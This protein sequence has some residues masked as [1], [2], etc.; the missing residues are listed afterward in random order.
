MKHLLSSLL[1]LA[2]MS[3]ASLAHAQQ[4]KV[5]KVKGQQ[6]I[7]QFPNGVP[8]VV[9][10]MIP[11]GGSE[12]QT[13]TGAK[14]R[15]SRAHVLAVAGQIYFT[16]NSATSNSTTGFKLRGSYG[17]NQEI[18]EFGP[19]AELDYASTTGQ[20]SRTLLGGGFFDFN[21]VPNKPGVETVYGVGATA[22]AGQ[23]TT[24]TGS[25]DLTSSEFDLFAGANAKWFGL[26]DN[27]ALRADAGFQMVRTSVNGQAT[28]NS[29]LQILAGL[30]FYF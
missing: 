26:S 2:S 8:P 14:P 5:I 4:A 19:L 23:Q 16:N 17:W 12:V 11:V 22:D 10:E 15:G 28:T 20:S 27:V 29:G 6:A 3:V 30:S 18:F 1:V 13:E 9:G 7:V 21:F 25:T 24:T